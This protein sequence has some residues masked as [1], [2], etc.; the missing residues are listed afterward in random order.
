MIRDILNIICYM[1]HVM[2]TPGFTRAAFYTVSS[3]G[4]VSLLFII[5]Y[6]LKIMRMR[7]IACWVIVIIIILL[8]TD[9]ASQ[10]SKDLNLYDD[11]LLA[12][13]SLSLSIVGEG[14]SRHIFAKWSPP[15][16]EEGTG[17]LLSWSLARNSL[18]TANAFLRSL[19]EPNTLRYDE[20]TFAIYLPGGNCNYA[21]NLT[22]TTNKSEQT[23]TKKI[24]FPFPS[25]HRFY[26][27]VERVQQ[28][29]RSYQSRGHKP[30]KTTANCFEDD[31]YLNNTASD[32][33]SWKCARCP[34][35]AS[36]RGRKIWRDVQSKAGF[37]RLQQS[38]KE[39][40][41]P[42][43][44]WP[45]AEPLACMGSINTQL[46]SRYH[47]K[48]SLI[49]Q[50]KNLSSIL[51]RDQTEKCNGDLGFREKC[52]TLSGEETRCSLCRACKHGF[53]PTRAARCTKCPTQLE[54]FAVVLLALI[55]LVLVLRMFL[56]KESDGT[57]DSPHAHLAQPLQKVLL[58]HWH[59]ISLAGSL[60]LRWPVDLQNFFSAWQVLTRFGGYLFTPQCDLTNATF[61]RMRGESSTFFVKQLMVLSLPFVSVFGAV[62]VWT[63]V[64]LW[65]QIIET[66]CILRFRHIIVRFQR[67]FG[68]CCYCLC[69]CCRTNKFSDGSDKTLNASELYDKFHQFA[70][71][72]ATRYS[73]G[74]HHLRLGRLS[75]FDLLYALSV[76]GRHRELYTRLHTEASDHDDHHDIMIS[77][78]IPENIVIGTDEVMPVHFI[79]ASHAV[80]L[81]VPADAIPGQMYDVALD[82]GSQKIL[83]QMECA[84]LSMKPEHVHGTVNFE[85]FL[86]WYVHYAHY[87]HAHAESRRKDL[88]RDEDVVEQLDCVLHIVSGSTG[89]KT[90]V[91]PF[92]SKMMTYQPGNDTYTMSLDAQIPGNHGMNCVIHLTKNR[93]IRVNNIAKSVSEGWMTVDGTPLMPGK[94]HELHSESLIKVCA[95]DGTEVD[96][97]AEVA[98]TGMY[99]E[100]ESTGL[101]AFRIPSRKELEII[102][103]DALDAQISRAAVLAHA[104]AAVKAAH[105][106]LE[107]TIFR[108]II[109]S[110]PDIFGPNW[111]YKAMAAAYVRFRLKCREAGLDV[112]VPV[113]S[114][115]NMILEGNDAVGCRLEIFWA[116]GQSRKSALDLQPYLIF[117]KLTTKETTKTREESNI[118]RHQMFH[119]RE[120][121]VKRGCWYSG[122]IDVYDPKTKKYHFT[123]DDKDEW[124]YDLKSIR[125]RFKGYGVIQK[126]AAKHAKAEQF[127][128]FASIAFSVS[129]Q[130]RHYHQ[131][132][133]RAR[134][135]HHERRSL[136]SKSGHWSAGLVEST[137]GGG[138][139]SSI[140]NGTQSSQLH[141]ASERSSEIRH[142]DK[143]IATIVTILY[144][145]Y[146]T[147]CA[148]AFSLA[149][150]QP[151]GNNDQLFLQ[152][153][154]E[155]QCYGEIHL[156]WFLL[157]CVPAVLA[158]VV[159]IPV[160]T[161]ILLRKYRYQ[162]HHRRMQYRY[163]LLVVGFKE[164]AYYWE[165]LITGRKIGT[166]AIGVYM[167]RDDPSIQA[168]SSEILVVAA[169]IAHITF[170]PYHEVTPNHNTLQIAE[171]LAL[172]SAFVTLA[173]GIA[174]TESTTTYGT[175]YTLVIVCV[176]T[177]FFVA[178]LWWYF[179]LARMDLENM[180]EKAE[181]LHWL[182]NGSLQCLSKLFP[183]WEMKGRAA[184]F[185]REENEAIEDLKHMDLAWARRIKEIGHR[186]VVGFRRN[187]L[188]DDLVR[189]V[190]IGHGPIEL[191]SAESA[192]KRVEIIE[193][194]S[195]LAA[196][197]F[198]L[199]VVEKQQKSQFRLQRRRA[200]QH[201]MK[202]K[203]S[204]VKFV[205]L[206][207]PKNV[208]MKGLGFKLK[209]K[210]G[211]CVVYDLQIG[212]IGERQGLKNGIKL[213]LV[214]GTPIHADNLTT[215]QLLHEKRP[216]ELVFG[217]E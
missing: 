141:E 33:L 177:T 206:V 184:E 183:D 2:F 167:L 51:N 145:L 143:I 131:R 175:F 113:G 198:H 54:R 56:S 144:L 163:G 8:P 61:N 73:D 24:I 37:F 15:F 197:K 29:R 88:D 96:I 112:T 90:I 115:E 38:P 213:L 44:F 1:L 108:S 78:M 171:T 188:G 68:W 92:S 149:A 180:I 80:S 4:T 58:N 215:K 23:K 95:S 106:V 200:S 133:Q 132:L 47:T 127:A 129:L 12:P 189:I 6:L 201:N 70:H 173:C 135:R 17:S 64:R 104:F 27:H 204:E 193:K 62:L 16:Q 146:P 57:G 158:L 159:C 178:G 110:H 186:W 117:A 202:R 20:E 9:K 45:C 191:T 35:G 216:L 65:P 55:F 99:H 101:C 87:V 39:S 210:F 155:V 148:S 128:A 82:P 120:R 84:Y 137:H 34:T 91:I 212:S 165:L 41:H 43:V 83:G 194:Q 72:S 79:G 76:D 94:Q 124:W 40:K 67:K 71:E 25:E 211:K 81:L 14:S 111:P 75:I 164:D 28:N 195:E 77:I 172:T 22:F 151:V 102:F 11:Q 154:L 199:G 42:S 114:I 32:I 160:F 142:S 103:T 63:L 169:L 60:P 119:E 116:D 192:V 118:E 217:K 46:E 52:I 153:D 176:N 100:E 89:A 19:V 179:T 162:M 136:L 174:L 107:W 161:F 123:Y 86:K 31:M 130:R 214:G 196:E 170:Q 48:W 3:R 134:Q 85:N 138:V 168:L 49:S 152:Q 208:E 122:I 93:T 209:W 157:L 140:S 185:D 26:V 147:L 97:I 105:T 18:P 30:W 166:A 36:C 66:P 205:H 150:C 69:F 7:T 203:D 10:C 21:I 98:E 50:Y 59:L 207:V 126:L 125:H 139:S 109:R 182:S 181:E 13:T 53:Y 190:P 5:Y 156:K 121:D 74:T 187:K